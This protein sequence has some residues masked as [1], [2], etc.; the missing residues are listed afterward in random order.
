M[1][2]QIT[3]KLLKWKDEKNRKPL[4][5]TGVRQCGKTYILK[6][7][8]EEYFKSYLYINFERETSLADVFEYDL[9]PERIMKEISIL[10]KKPQVIK[11][12]TLVIFDEIQACPRAITA[13]HYIWGGIWIILFF[14]I[15][16]SQKRY[17]AQIL[18][19]ECDPEERCGNVSKRLHAVEPDERTGSDGVKQ[20][21]N[22]KQ[23]RNVENPL[24][25]YRYNKGGIVPA[26]VLSEHA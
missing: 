19:H 22:S 11:G 12:E 21:W 14:K 18:Y 10:L 3:Q 16:Q 5:I 1:K 15:L 7:F 20:R 9:N 13:F 2:R 23:Y 17:G 8:A 6:K 25:G 4:M 26:D 24:P